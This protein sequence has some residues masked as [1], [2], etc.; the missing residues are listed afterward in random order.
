MAAEDVELAGD[1]VSEREMARLLDTDTTKSRQTA[2]HLP[3]R[4][5]CL[6]LTIISVGSLIS[7]IGRSSSSTR[8][9][10]LKTTHRILPFAM[11]ARSASSCG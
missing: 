1:R 2:T 5:V 9:G 6:T 11:C 10:P 7:G 8:R 4:A 3:H